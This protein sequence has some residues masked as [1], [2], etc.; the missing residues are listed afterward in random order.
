[1]KQ[2]FFDYL[3]TFGWAIIGSLAMGVGLLLCLKMFAW[4]TDDIDEWAELKNNNLS[5]AVV[6]A[7]II[8]ACAWVVSSV[9]RP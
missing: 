5:V 9:I 7:S 2:V 6:L 3:V 8:L 1:M 4:A